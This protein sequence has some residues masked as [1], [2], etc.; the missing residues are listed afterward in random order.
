MRDIGLNVDYQATEFGSIMQRRNNADKPGVWSA[1]P[2]SVNA[3]AASIPGTNYALNGY[4][5]SPD[6]RMTRYIEDWF[7]APDLMGQRTAAEQIQTRFLEAPSYIPLCQ[8]FNAIAHRT[9][10]TDIVPGYN[11]RCWGLRKA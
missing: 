5:I 7:D 6:P 9:N 10:V 1:Y 11:L 3:I 8:R 4:G 2:S